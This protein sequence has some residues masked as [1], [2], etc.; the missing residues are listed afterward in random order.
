MHQD[1]VGTE[2]SQPADPYNVHGCQGQELHVLS[3]FVCVIVE[4]RQ[5]TLGAIVNDMEDADNVQEIEG[6]SG[7]S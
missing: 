1:A 4:D 6:S 7:I 2:D 3:A 5:G